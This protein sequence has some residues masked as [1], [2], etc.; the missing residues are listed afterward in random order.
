M[1]RILIVIFSF[2]TVASFA[3]TK[4][5]VKFSY[6]AKKKANG[7]YDILITAS[8]QKPWH[9]YSQNTEKGGPLPTKINFSPNPLLT[10][11]G[12]VKEEG[13]LEKVFDENFK[14][15]VLYYS[16]KVVFVQ[17]V[18]LKGKVQTNITGNIKYMVCDDEMC[19]P[20]TKKSFDIKLQ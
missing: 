9:I 13:K 12:K 14:K 18:K 19:L 1:K 2:F 11:Q 10:L 3:Q 20:P 4:D 5:V 6:E 8:L 17:T 16:N 15:N 7:E